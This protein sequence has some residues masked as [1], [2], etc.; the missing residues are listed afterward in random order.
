MD[1]LEDGERE[2]KKGGRHTVKFK[3]DNVFILVK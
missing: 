2:K 3:N 1:A